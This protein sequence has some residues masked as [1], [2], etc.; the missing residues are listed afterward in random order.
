M[1]AIAREEGLP[2]FY[3]GLLAS[4]LREMTYSALRLGLYAPIRDLSLAV[5]QR[6]SKP[7]GNEAPFA[8]KIGAGLICGCIGAAATNPADL[9]KVRLMVAHTQGRVGLGIAGE[10]RELLHGPGGGIHAL[11]RGVAPNVQ[12]AALVTASQVGTYDEIKFRIKDTGILG[13]ELRHDGAKEPTALH[14]AAAFGASFFAAAIT[15]PV[16]TVKTRLMASSAPTSSI[17]D[18]NLI[19]TSTVSAQ[20]VPSTVSALARILREEGF[21]GAYKGFWPTWARLCL[22]TVC[23][24]TAYEA[25]RDAVGLRPL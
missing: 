15:T 11:W 10:L 23:T 13:T 18:I 3:R 5:L 12:R 22:H 20:P 25:L 14:A 6:D 16:D 17:V 19:A 8:V 9:I 7:V 4:V 1:I 21:A 24:F 2:G